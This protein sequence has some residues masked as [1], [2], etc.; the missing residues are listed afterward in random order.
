MATTCARE[1]LEIVKAYSTNGLFLLFLTTVTRVTVYRLILAGKYLD[2]RK[3]C[4]AKLIFTA[5]IN[6]YTVVTNKG[7]N[8][9]NPPLWSYYIIAAELLGAVSL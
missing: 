1:L 4:F 3:M 8:S 2:K 5:K 6:R 7:K 9:K